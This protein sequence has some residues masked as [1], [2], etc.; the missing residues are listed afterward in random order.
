MNDAERT[1]LL[2][3]LAWQHAIGVDAVVA[4]DALPWPGHGGPPT[5]SSYLDQSLKS[6]AGRAV[7]GWAPARHVV[8]RQVAGTGHDGGTRQVEARPEQGTREPARPEPASVGDALPASNALTLSDLRR[9]LEA[10]DGCALKRTAKNLCVFRGAEH[11]RVMVIGEAPGRDEDLQGLPFVGR[12]GVLLDRMLAAID[13][14]PSDVHITNVV[15]WR[16]PGNRTPTDVE[17]AACAP[18]L[19]RQIALVDPKIIVLL[20]GVAAKTILGTTLGITKVRG[21]WH[22]LTA[23]G[24]DRAAIATLHPAYLLRTPAAKRMAWLDLLSLRQRLDGEA[25]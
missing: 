16:P 7:E 12:A 20:G 4:D 1:I 25:P 5:V 10:F 21:S 15:Y 24:K 19:D 6:E 8:G 17:T 14:G 13:L 22:E 23:G 2:R 3:A 9:S 18:F 11:A